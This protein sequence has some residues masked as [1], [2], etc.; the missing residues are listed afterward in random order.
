MSATILVKNDKS[1]HDSGD[2]YHRP[3]KPPLILLKPLNRILRILGTLNQL[4]NPI[5]R[6]CTLP[7]RRT[8][9]DRTDVFKDTVQLIRRRWRGGNFQFEL[10]A[11]LAGVRGV[12]AGLVF[13]CGFGGG[14]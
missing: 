7:T 12:V 14:D 13:C 10:A 8:P 5:N 1:T 9:R 2:T 11:L 6:L 4:P 3:N